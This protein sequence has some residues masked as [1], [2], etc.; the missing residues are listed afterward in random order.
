[1]AGDAT[2]RAA[3]SFSRLLREHRL[4]ASLTQ[5]ELATRS[6]LSV[7][8]ISML[9]RGVRHAPRGSTVELLAGALELD[10]P[11]R[12]A[13]IAAANRRP[14]A[15][16][17]AV[18]VP[19]DLGMALT[20]LIGRTQDLARIRA[21]LSRPD[22]RLLTLTG[23]PGS[24]KTR[25]ALE[26]ATEVRD[27]YRDGVVIVTLGSLRDTGL[28][29]PAV[30]Q[31]LGLR[32]V[33]NESTL[34][35]VVGHCR[36]RE[37]LLVIDN[38]EHLLAAAPDLVELLAR[39]PGL[40][41]MVTSRAV[42]RVR[43]EHE[44]AVPPLELPSAEQERARDP[45]V[46]ADVAAVRLF[47]DRAQATAPDFLLTADN[48]D[49]VV[50]ICRR[51]DGLPLAL[52]LAAPWLKLLMPEDLLGRLDHRLELLVQGPRDLP[53]RQRTMRATLDWSCGLLEEAPRALLRRLSVFA[54]S[55]PLDGLERV[56]Q[57][58]GS[59]PDGVLQHLAVLMEHRLIQRDEVA[60]ATGAP[61]VTMLES[62]RDYAREMLV[63]AGE[64]EVTA[65]AHLEEYAELATRKYAD[66]GGRTQA[67]WLERLRR[68]HDNV[69]AALG[70]AVEHGEVEAGLRLAEG[71]W[72]FWDWGGHRQEG[73]GW[74]EWLLAADVQ[75]AP[76]VRA[77]ALQGAGALAYR[78]GS[79]DL[80]I[81][82]HEAAL[83]IFQ[84]LGDLSATA[85][86]LWR[87]ARAIGRR[88][89]PAEAT[90]LLEE[91]AALLRKLDDRPLLADVLVDL[92]MYVA[93]RE[94]RRAVVL[95][96]EA[97]AIERSV[98]DTLGA[99]FCLINLGKMAS[100][101]GDLDLARARIEEGEASARRLDAPFHRAVA[102]ANLGSLD[103]IGGDMV[104]AA[105]RTR[106][107]LALFLRIQDSYGVAIC[108]WELAWLAW[109]ASMAERAVR[110]YGAANGI[111]PAVAATQTYVESS[112]HEEAFAALREQL[113]DDR[114][115]AAYEAGGR[116]SAEEAATEASARV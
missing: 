11:Q 16:T 72:L 81:A 113:G 45:G 97:L 77:R 22:L 58:A 103:R 88:G 46:L 109:N 21:M 115:E 27:D 7:Q 80:S 78:L 19:S 24:G 4:A 76:A 75:V 106:E 48:A 17:A 13:L 100:I 96:E 32:E 44:L 52:E 89:D 34:D 30:R 63:E 111:C 36:E 85:D 110:L 55:A 66:T 70:W 37:L 41:A 10:G 40:N 104:A 33:G 59:L 15:A 3:R 62:V 114:F 53:E 43:M 29:M 28:V 8:G 82:R 87:I 84:E 92:S 102:L 9:E 94:P 49:V 105:A 54:G 23:P 67:S 56:C 5:E 20:P 90:R 39:C 38:F 73:F 79:Y 86:I 14:D 74:L 68:E 98:G 71:L 50:S 99:A 42:L 2:D 116:L 6:G 91:A 25:L 18:A 95:C 51:L 47:L 61:H 93:R 108:L 31:A 69:R 112:P 1:M 107:S 35:T 65:R 12:Q 26:V 60:L 101:L 83:A 57:A 64:L